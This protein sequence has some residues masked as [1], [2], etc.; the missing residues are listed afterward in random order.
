ME[1]KQTLSWVTP[2]KNRI[3]EGSRLA[4]VII[5]VVAALIAFITIY[6][7]Y[8]VLI[9]SLSAPK[10]AMSLQVYWAPV[11]INLNAY[12]LLV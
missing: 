2:R 10:A 7:M 5:Y 6:P 3:R 12:R 4:T 1:K 9:L 8:Y 11:G